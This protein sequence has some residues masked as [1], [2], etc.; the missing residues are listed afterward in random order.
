MIFLAGIHGAGK[1]TFCSRVEKELG[2]KCW[3]ASGLIEAVVKQRMPENKEIKD[4]GQNQRLLEY[5]V[6]ILGISGESILMEGHLCLLNEYG[7]ID[8]R[9]HV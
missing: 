1:T 5:A 9:A 8:R 3:S 2:V 6:R 7:E 4:I